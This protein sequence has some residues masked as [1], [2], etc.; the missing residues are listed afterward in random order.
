MLK[1]LK[2]LK[3]MKTKKMMVH[4]LLLSSVWLSTCALADST[5]LGR[6]MTTTDKPTNAQ[7]NLL[8]QMIQVRFPIH[9]KTVGEAISYLLNPSG[10]GLV[11]KKQRDHQLRTILTKPLPAVDRNFG[12]MPLDVALTTLV[13]P[14]FT[15]VHDPINRTINLTVKPQFLPVL[16]KP[17]IKHK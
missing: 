7:I 16:T 5:Q 8:S 13:G 14:A 6:Y 1:T 4:V 2:T 9:V 3:K 11:D 10:Y 15:L 12:P 17:I